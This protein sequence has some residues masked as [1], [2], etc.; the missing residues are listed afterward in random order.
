MLELQETSD[1]DELC[2]TRNLRMIVINSRTFDVGPTEQVTFLVIK[3]K[4][5]GAVSGSATT[6]SGPLPLTVTGPQRVTIGVTFTT[7]SGG[8]ADI[9]AISDLAGNSVDRI[10]QAAPVPFRTR[11]YTLI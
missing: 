7:S 4:Q 2:A 11:T 5:V 8:F 6:V 1:Q 9:Q 3:S 10:E